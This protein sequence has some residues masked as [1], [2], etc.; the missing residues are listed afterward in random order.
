MRTRA[1]TQRSAQFQA[2]VFRDASSEGFRK[3]NLTAD[4][5]H[6]E[7]TNKQVDSRTWLAACCPVLHRATFGKARLKDWPARCVRQRSS[8]TDVFPGGEE[9]LYSD[10]EL[11][12]PRRSPMATILVVEDDKLSQRLLSK[13]LASAGHVALTADSV[14]AAWELLQRAPTI[15]LAILDNQLGKGWGWELLQRIRGDIVFQHLPVV[16]YTAHTERSSIL[17]YV[18]HRVQS[19]LVKPYKA[20]VILAEA[21]KAVSADWTSRLIEP[22]ASAAKRLGI[23]QAD[24]YSTLNATASSLQRTIGEVREA[25][26]TRSSDPRVGEQ[27]NRIANEAVTL[28]M[29]PLRAAADAL[30]RSIN[31]RNTP[32]IMAGLARLDSL[33]RLVSHRAHVYLGVSEIVSVPSKSLEPVRTPTRTYESPNTAATPVAAFVRRTGAA[34]LWYFGRH[35]QELPHDR[36]ALAAKLRQ[37]FVSEARPPLITAFLSAFD[38]LKALPA[39]GLDEVRAG[40]ASLGTFEPRFL[41]ITRRLGSFEDEHTTLDTALAI[42]RLGVYRSGVFMTCARVALAT[43]NDTPL[44]LSP[45]LQHTLTSTLVAYELGHSLRATDENVCASAGLAHDTGK[46]IMAI[47]QPV[48]YGL[49]T[50]MTLQDSVE[51]SEAELSLFG[52]THEELG[53]GFL[54]ASTS[55]PLLE[56]VA[57]F[58]R[59][60]LGAPPE[61]AVPVAIAAIASELAWSAAAESDE[62]RQAAGATL[63]RADHP[64]WLALKRAAVE[65]PMELPEL[66]DSLQEVATTA[67]WIAAVIGDWARQQPAK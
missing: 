1:V 20:D 15:D 13:I 11:L 12:T 57:R 4:V 29:P 21:A 67:N 6:A 28:G 8:R 24:Y 38:F 52:I 40:V 51:M 39:L 2:R 34:P 54:A 55:S 53:A 30:A 62:Q 22:A 25:L 7:D 27:L 48:L 10:C 64:A 61:Y 59:S 49:A 58:H 47:A 3:A 17:K 65:L 19:M 16:V 9:A 36:Q 42:H 45:L 35:A 66:I 23:T 63:A 44:D 32:E 43:P 41:S 14:A 50:S 56:Q 37:R 60:P 18:E 46:W 33:Q 5:L 31:L 26:K